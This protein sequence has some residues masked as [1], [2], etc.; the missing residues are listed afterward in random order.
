MKY[1]LDICRTWWGCHSA[2]FPI[3]FKGA[4]LHPGGWKG[5]NYISQSSLQLGFWAQIKLSLRWPGW[6]GR[7]RVYKKEMS[8]SLFSLLAAMFSHWLPG[9]M[10]LWSSFSDHCALDCQQL[11]WWPWF[12]ASTPWQWWQQP[13]GPSSAV[14]PGCHLELSLDPLLSFQWQPFLPTLLWAPTSHMKPLSASRSYDSFCY[15]RPPWSRE[16][17]RDEGIQ[18]TRQQVCC[19][20]RSARRKK[21]V[22]IWHLRLSMKNRKKVKGHTI[23]NYPDEANTVGPE[24]KARA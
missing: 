10:A 3:Y 13:K 4:F 14:L 2:F 16:E 5:V 23:Q 24:V 19:L 22:S 15:P 17:G 1:V 7:E 18:G 9:W 11:L 8:A 12:P 21:F 6:E 20:G